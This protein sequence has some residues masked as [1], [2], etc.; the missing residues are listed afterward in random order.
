MSDAL[1][2]FFKHP[3]KGTNEEAA[4]GDSNKVNANSESLKLFGS[5]RDM[6]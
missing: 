5:Y 3:A 2:A 6:I 1:C 4:D